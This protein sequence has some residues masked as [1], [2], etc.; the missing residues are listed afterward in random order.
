MRKVKLSLATVL[1]ATFCAAAAGYAGKVEGAQAACAAGMP[2]LEASPMQTAPGQ[3]L[4]LHGQG[5]FGDFVC[6]DT[7]PAFLSR[8][9]GGRPTGD[10]RVEFVQGTR[11]WTLA[12]VASDEKLEFDAEGLTV[13]ADAAPGEA[14]VR[15]TSPYVDPSIPPP[16]AEAPLLVLGHLPET[17]GPEAT[18]GTTDR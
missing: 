13:P 9:A 12:T 6:D 18:T 15:A 5:F 11:T 16:R 10:I 1:L 4:R 2:R 3:A 7:G 14:I 8:P 17:G